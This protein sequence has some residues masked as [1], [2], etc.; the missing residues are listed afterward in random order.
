MHL[1]PVLEADADEP[2][3]CQLAQASKLLKALLTRCSEIIAGLLG[4]D[5]NH[6]FAPDAAR[7]RTADVDLCDVWE[8]TVRPPAPVPE[9]L[10]GVT[11]GYQP[12]VMHSRR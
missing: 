7:H 12:H 11:W 4:G 5:M 3:S 8:D 10:R 2:S 1:D 9:R 6:M